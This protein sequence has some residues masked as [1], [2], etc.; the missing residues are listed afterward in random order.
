[1]CDDC[2]Y[3]TQLEDIPAVHVYFK[4]MQH[5]KV[6]WKNPALRWCS[7]NVR[8]EMKSKKNTYYVEQFS[9]SVEFRGSP[10]RRWFF[11]CLWGRDQGDQGSSRPR[12]WIYRGN[13]PWGD[14]LQIDLVKSGV[15]EWDDV[16]PKP[17]SGRLFIFSPT[18]FPRFGP[19][20]I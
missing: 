7:I 2:V 4:M 14:P 16:G 15:F 8:P 3:D 19:I 11:D 12:I 10:D 17:I 18:G 20:A 9:L 13:S 5:N 6:A 1:M